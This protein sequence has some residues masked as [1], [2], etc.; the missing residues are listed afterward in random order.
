MGSMMRRHKDQAFLT[1]RSVIQ[2][3]PGAPRR[4][5]QFGRAQDD[6]TTVA[7]RSVR[8]VPGR[9]KNMS[10]AEGLTDAGLRTPRAAA[11]AGVAFRRSL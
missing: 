3:R 9:V 6:A 2:R 1:G 8:Q 7:V 10:Q 11:V 4:K 5:G